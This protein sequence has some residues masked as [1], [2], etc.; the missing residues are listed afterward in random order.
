MKIWL[1][2]KTSAWLP[3]LLAS[4]I[5]TMIMANL[6][7]FGVQRQ[8]DEGTPAHIFQLGLVCELVLMA[9]FAIHWLPHSPRDGRWILVIQVLAVAAQCAPVIYFDW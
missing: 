5:L 2:K 9:Y 8:I 1:L 7:L 6:V 3:L 4:V